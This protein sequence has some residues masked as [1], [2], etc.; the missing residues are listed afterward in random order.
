MT[1]N[2]FNFPETNVIMCCYA[3]SFF[4]SAGNCPFR[5][6]DFLPSSLANTVQKTIHSATKTPDKVPET[7]ELKLCSSMEIG[8]YT[9]L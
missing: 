5:W 8:G 7:G 2:H 1:S 3:M 9:T 4:F 6:R